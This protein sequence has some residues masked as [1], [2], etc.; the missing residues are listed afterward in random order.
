MFASSILLLI[1]LFFTS[2]WTKMNHAFPYW[3]I[4]KRV[5]KFVCDSIEEFESWQEALRW[6][7]S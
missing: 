2:F 6:R 3:Q 5:L 7:Y 4:Y 1:H